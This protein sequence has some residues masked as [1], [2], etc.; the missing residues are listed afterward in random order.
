MS[1]RI[2]SKRMV[3]MLIAVAVLF[4]L[5]FGFKAFKNH[6]I[7]QFLN[8]MPHPAA[9]ISTYKA[10]KDQWA[11]SLNAVGTV[12]AING[13]DV[14]TQVGG[15]VDSIQFQSGD[16]VK[17]GDVLVTLEAG[18][19]KAQLRALQ[20]SAKLAELQFNRYQR[21]Y[22]Q[23]NVSK[24]ELDNYRAQRDQAVAQ[25][26]AQQEQ[27]GYKTVRAPFDGVL[28]IRK[29]DLGEYLQPGTPVV[30]LDQLSPIYVNFSLPEQD[31]SQVHKGLKV[32]TT[33]DAY[34]NQTFD[35][36]ISAIEPGVDKTTRNFTAQATFANDDNKLRP[37]MFAQVD[38]QLPQ[39]SD[40]V[41]VPRTAISYAPYG[42]TVY[43]VE[44]GPK[45]KDGK[46]QKIVKK[47]FVKLGMQRGDLIAVLKGVKPGETVAT[48]GLLKLQNNAP[49]VIN[50]SVKPS[51]EAN[52]H[53]DNS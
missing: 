40:V 43:V 22:K 53:P 13:V 39:S 35:G 51:A 19:A 4:G 34:P 3:I 41:V 1:K 48:S 17:K 42:D 33:L 25:A 49:V 7:T 12:N 24:S 23:G 36:T 9:T 44:D 8:N 32:H 20:A 11:L 31:L 38:I 28:G 26:Q 47:R 50:N 27:V 29:V 6:M 16:R 10:H 30:S 37:G 46:A 14:T 45:G 2:V 18:S 52:P 15:E 21:L 5:V